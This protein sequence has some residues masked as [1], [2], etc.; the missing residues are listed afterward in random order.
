MMGNSILAHASKV[1]A[2][3]TV[4]VMGLFLLNCTGQATGKTSIATQI[5]PFP[6]AIPNEYSDQSTNDLPPGPTV[7]LELTPTIQV[8]PSPNEIK[9]SPSP[10][11]PSHPLNFLGP[12]LLGF[13]NQNQA[14]LYDLGLDQYYELSSLIHQP[15]VWSPDGCSILF[16]GTGDR[17]YKTNI[18]SFDPQV[19]IPNSNWVDAIWLPSNNGIIYTER[20]SAY[21]ESPIEIF[22]LSSETDSPIMLTHD[23]YQNKLFGTTPTNDEIIILASHD[24]MLNQLFA[25]DIT[26]NTS[27]LISDLTFLNELLTEPELFFVPAAWHIDEVGNVQLLLLIKDYSG[28]NNTYLMGIFDSKTNTFNIIK[29]VLEVAVSDGISEIEE[30]AFLYL[31]GTWTS[32]GQLLAFS[33]RYFDQDSEEKATI[34]FLDIQTNEFTPSTT[35]TSGELYLTFSP[36]DNMIAVQ[37]G[38]QTYLYGISSGTIRPL[39]VDF[40]DDLPLSWSPR[41]IYQVEDC[42]D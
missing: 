4:L 6:S 3:L 37:G 2:F 42:L 12:L 26:H 39:D 16:R 41:L 33:A 34:Y 5:T 32:T 19:V 36:D 21:P 31:G 28:W 8:I 29:N 1:K 20:T 17:L 18:R 40:Y 14:V 11:E 24:R 15:I 27:R 7:V 30:E 9:P 35:F 13:S 38:T 25:I 10:R 22:L 23:G